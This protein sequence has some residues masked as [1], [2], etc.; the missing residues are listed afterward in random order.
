MLSLVALQDNE[1]E[2]STLAVTCIYHVTDS[3]S[4]WE[5]HAMTLLLLP[6]CHVRNGI[7]FHY[8]FSFS[9]FLFVKQ[10]IL[11]SF[12]WPS[13]HFHVF[14]PTQYFFS[15]WCLIVGTLCSS[16]LFHLYAW[17]QPP[18]L[19]WY[20]QCIT[21]PFQ[22]FFQSAWLIFYES[23]LQLL[24]VFLPNTIFCFLPCASFFYV[25]C[26]L[27][28]FL[29]LFSVFIWPHVHLKTN[30]EKFWYLFPGTFSFLIR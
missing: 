10:V 23:L 2:M 11:F 4:S 15:L 21:H 6:D 26:N 29:V 16:F 9:L 12:T 27:A 7:P 28:F 19:W 20:L 3:D 8:I 5:S 13:S 30:F 18:I 1:F 24:S 25:L 14:L 17:V 22:R